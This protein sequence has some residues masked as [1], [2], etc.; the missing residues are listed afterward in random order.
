MNQ[1]CSCCGAEYDRAGPITDMCRPCAH[2]RCDSYPGSC[3]WS[4]G[5][6]SDVQHTLKKSENRIVQAHGSSQARFEIRQDGLSLYDTQGLRVYEVE[7]P[8][9]PANKAGIRLGP[10]EGE[11]VECGTE[12]GVSWKGPSWCGECRPYGFKEWL[13][14]YSWFGRIISPRAHR[15]GMDG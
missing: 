7:I 1:R 14:Y 8:F 11:C 15:K 6:K 12:L 3:G 13:I 9:D 2:S 4:I 5:K 10:R